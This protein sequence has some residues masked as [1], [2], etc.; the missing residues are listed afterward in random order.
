MLTA[1]YG[2][3]DPPVATRQSI[4]ASRLCTAFDLRVAVK[5]LIYRHAVT[6]GQFVLLIGGPGC[7]GK[8]TFA[9]ELAR[10]LTAQDQPT[11]VLDLD[12][13]LIER[14]RRRTVDGPISGYDPAGYLLCEARRDIDALL[15]GHQIVISPYDKV[16]GTRAPPIELCRARH[17]IIEGSMALRDPI[18][19]FGPVSLFLDAPQEVLY[20]NRKQRELTYG[21]TPDEIDHKFELLVQDYAKY[22]APQR[23]RAQLI[24]EIDERYA[25][26]S[27]K[28]GLG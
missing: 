28:V 14:S 9:T 13:Y 1:Q 16:T 17:L 20:A 27:L 3:L 4:P 6:A 11:I 24:V 19:P 23:S 8:S 7:A 15:G 25:F 21:S 2:D 26:L 10:E 22:I 18:Y 5:H 12:C